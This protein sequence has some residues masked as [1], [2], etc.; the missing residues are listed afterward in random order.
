MSNDLQTEKHCY[1]VLWEKTFYPCIKFYFKN[2]WNKAHA[3]LTHLFLGDTELFTLQGHNQ[4]PSGS[5]FQL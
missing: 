4:G 1:Q 2:L 5:P 3:Y